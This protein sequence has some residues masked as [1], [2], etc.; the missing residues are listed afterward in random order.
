[1]DAGDLTRKRHGQATLSGFQTVLNRHSVGG[2]ATYDSVLGLSLSTCVFSTPTTGVCGFY[3]GHST[4]KIRY[5]SYA[6]LNDVNDGLFGCNYKSRSV[7]NI[8]DLYSV[9]S[10]VTTSTIIDTISSSLYS[11]SNQHICPKISYIVPF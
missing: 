11:V 5:P 6:F 7:E 2:P 1:M 4:C 8:I 10:S 3:S 9:K